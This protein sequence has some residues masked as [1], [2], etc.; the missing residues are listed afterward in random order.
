M[1]TRS[2]STSP[3]QVDL[4]HPEFKRNPYPYWAHLR[5]RSPVFRTYVQRRPA[6]LITRHA[7]VAATLR[8]SR[9]V[10]DRH[11]VGSR[12][13]M[14][15]LPGL[16]IM[17]ALERS[18]LDVDG[19]D[20]ARLRRLVHQA[21]TPR[22][23]EAM[24]GRIQA[25]TDAL[26][27][28]MIGRGPRVDLI[29]SLALPL[30]VTVISDILGIPAGDRGQFHHW[31]QQALTVTG[32]GAG[33]VGTVRGIGAIL[34][35]FRYVRRLIRRKRDDPQDDLLTAL[36]QADD[37]GDCL[38]EDELIAMVF[39]LLI[40]GH[41]TTVNLTG[42]G[43]LE[44]LR[45]PEQ[46]EQLQAAPGLIR[47]AVEELAR[48]ASPVELATERYASADVE[49]NGVT[50]PRGELVFAVL[51]SANRDPEQFPRPDELDL[52]RNTTGHLAFGLGAHY[53]VGAP[54]ARLE[55]QVALATLLARFP[56]LR[57][58]IAP[59]RLE[60][61]PQLVLRGLKAL[62]VHLGMAN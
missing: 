12:G 30:P 13:L 57:L 2:L 47:P 22:R 53:C 10:K 26:L 28:D 33:I 20:H 32:S 61:R 6:C 24:R 9:F 45:H 39:I 43:V 25:T 19:E 40:A 55:V 49:V 15:S 11:T 35:M 31:T 37:A 4:S 56:H 21:F 34:T 29:A 59:E 36:V 51:A 16:K 46:L 18:M 52:G 42:N 44:L 23:V 1:S 7:D 54:L 5:E 48:Y 17:Q 27:D 58:D 38:S 60:W 3:A 50:I 62:P 41:E 14:P 8:D